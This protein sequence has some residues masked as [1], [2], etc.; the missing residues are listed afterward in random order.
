MLLK[1]IENIAACEVDESII[2]SILSIE[3]DINTKE[4]SKLYNSICAKLLEAKQFYNIPK[5][6]PMSNNSSD[7][8]SLLEFKAFS[9]AHQLTL[10]E[11]DMINKIQTNE[12][13]NWL[14]L[15]N[16]DLSPNLHAFITR[17]DQ[18]SY[19]LQTQI[20]Q[21][22]NEKKAAEFGRHLMK[23]MSHLRKLNNFSSYMCLLSALDSSAI[24]RLP[25]KV[26]FKSELVN[27]LKL[28][29]VSQSFQVY[30]QALE[31]AKYPCIPYL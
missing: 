14:K 10:N 18:T 12:F 9:I 7:C 15:K 26:D 17:F 5:C 8:C 2:E 30:R 16:Y 4:G 11:V 6:V 29:D 27:Y 25:W 31:N 23:I 13:L 1:I 3:C 20:L 24:S 28:M 22:E 21:I 19:W